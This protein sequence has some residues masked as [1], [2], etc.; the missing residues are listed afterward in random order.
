MR[1]LM[2]IFMVVSMFFCGC[3]GKIDLSVTSPSDGETISGSSVTVTGTVAGMAETGVTVN[4]APASLYIS[5]AAVNQAVVNKVPPKAQ[6]AVNDVKLNSGQNTITVTATDVNG[7][8]VTKTINVNAVIPADFIKLSAHADSGI[9]PMEIKL[10]IDG[11]FNVG[12][13]AITVN[14]PGVGER[15]T[16]ENPDEFKYRITTDGIY[17]FTAQAVNSAGVTFS[18]TIAVTVLP[19]ELADALLMARWNKFRIAL[20]IQDVDQATMNFVSESRDTYKQMYNDL[21]PILTDIVRELNAATI[22][23]IS[24][25]GRMAVYEILVTRE[26]ATY[27]FQLEFVKD[28]AGIWKIH[29]F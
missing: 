23:F 29:K 28:E 4:G 19:L 18:D 10:R 6:F 20:N 1:K 27:S 3:S 22:N 17:Y 26:G 25:D 21:K 14:G 7:N 2:M 16:G 5:Q 9:S 13:P 24:L 11:S 12:S 8:T 15:M